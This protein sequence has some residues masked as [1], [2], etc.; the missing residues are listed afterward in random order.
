MESRSVH[1]REDVKK[2]RFIF[3]AILVPE[4]GG[5]FVVSFPDFPE[6]L[7]SGGDLEEALALAE[8]CLAEAVAGR[9]D[10]GEEIP[11]PS[12]SVAAHTVVLPAHIALKASLYLTMREAWVNKIALAKM[13]DVDEKEVRRMLD[14]HHGTRLQTMER[15]LKALGKRIHVQVA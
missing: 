6:A 3:P 15:T 4:E 10:D 2:D 8:D 11:V 7:T 1:G 5:G 12:E 13:M 9:I 14:P